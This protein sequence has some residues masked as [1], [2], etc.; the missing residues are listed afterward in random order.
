MDRGKQMPNGLKRFLVHNE[1]DV[2]VLMMHNKTYAAEI[3]HAVSSRKRISIIEK[4][5][6][7]GVKV[8][9]PNAKITTEV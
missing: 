7:L 9:N 1:K 8:T 4:A 5:R 6:Q 2:E 3:G